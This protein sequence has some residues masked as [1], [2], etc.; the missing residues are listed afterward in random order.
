[1][2]RCKEFVDCDFLILC[3]GQY[4]PAL[5]AGD[6]FVVAPEFLVVVSVLGAL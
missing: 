1:M 4:P 6:S 5:G 3:A 2:T